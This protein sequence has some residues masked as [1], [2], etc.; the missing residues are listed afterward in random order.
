MSQAST[1]ATSSSLKKDGGLATCFRSQTPE[2]RRDEKVVQDDHFETDPLAYRPR[3][4]VH[5]VGSERCVL[6]HPGSPHHR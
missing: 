5:V 3:G 1:A 2:L 6:S 4:L